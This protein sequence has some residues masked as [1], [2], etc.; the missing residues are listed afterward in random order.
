MKNLAF[1]F[2]ALAIMPFSNAEEPKNKVPQIAVHGEGILY[3]P[4]DQLQLV[5]GVVTQDPDP[6]KALSMNNDKMA[7][8]VASMKKTGL[9]SSE[10]QSG[11]FYIQPIYTNP[12]KDPKPDWQQKISH[13]EVSN[14]LQIKTQRLELAGTL[15]SAAAQAGANKIGE[16]QFVV[17]N[18]QQYHAEAIQLATAN[19]M[20]DAMVLSRAA[21]LQIVGIRSITLDHAR[22]HYPMMAK[23]SFDSYA[24][25]GATT[26]IEPGEVQIN[27]TV[28]MVFEIT[29]TFAQD[30]SSSKPVGK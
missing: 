29:S 30:P 13:Y 4:A 26:P 2:F 7:Q 14:N 19:A 8:L 25:G 5:I 15:I 28:D 22:P 17:K 18:P 12:P 10:Y 23:M 24:A 3:K 16:I 1:L 11:Q 21:G 27:A 6:Q 9:S 20:T